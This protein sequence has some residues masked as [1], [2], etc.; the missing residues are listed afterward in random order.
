MST[1]REAEYTIN[2]PP[3][4]ALEAAQQSIKSVKARIL[5]RQPNAIIA[6]TGESF[7]SHGEDIQISI[8]AGDANRSQLKIVSE[9][10]VKNALSDFGKN[11]SNLEKIMGFL[12]QIDTSKFKADYLPRIGANYSP[13]TS[14]EYSSTVKL[15]VNVFISYRRSDS[16]DITGRIYDSLVKK[17]GRDPIF[18]DVDSIP[19]GIDFKNYLSKE[20]GKCNVLLAI[21]GRQWVNASNANGKKRLDDPD[22]FVRIE[23]QSA[24][25]RAIPVIPLLVQGA[26]MPI[27]EDLPASL[28]SL[29]WRNG[30]QIR[31]DPDF[32]HDMHRLTSAL[33]KLSTKSW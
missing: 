4:I 12:K 8:I 6:Q 33:E 20:V 26:Q 17:F 32:H 19:L 10:V 25:E 27:E 28:R 18:K 11:A 29:V 30:I 15:P 13:A 23:I 24:L 9:C 31:P 22:D 16:A 5:E 14:M 21:I 7:K 1:K 3:E 2:L